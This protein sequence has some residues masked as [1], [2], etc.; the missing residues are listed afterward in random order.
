MGE[1]FGDHG[2]DETEENHPGGA[3]EE[4]GDHLM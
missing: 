3:E 2:G 1:E 4:T